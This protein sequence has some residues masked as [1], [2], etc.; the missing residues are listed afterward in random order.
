MKKQDSNTEL[1]VVDNDDDLLEVIGSELERELLK[2]VPDKD[3]TS[4][5]VNNKELLKAI[6]AYKKEC[7]DAEA[8]GKPLPRVSDYIGYCFIKMS[9]RIA[10]KP[11]FRNYPHI[12]EM[13]G[14]SI[15]NCLKYVRNFDE[16]KSN[17][18][19][20]YSTFIHNAFF[21]RIETEKKQLYVQALK[22]RRMG[23]LEDSYDVMDEDEADYH[24]THVAFLQEN[25][26]DI[27]TDFETRL[28][29]KR[30]KVN[31]RKKEKVVAK[32]LLD[33]AKK[34]PKAEK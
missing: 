4:H 28:K 29:K 23:N 27:I 7:D 26:D 15:E 30:D 33:K 8:L 32:G 22:V 18:F 17:P 5:Y 13:V 10:T 2:N 20:Y 14:D 12:E 9:E 21:R 31:L 6:V 11:C 24:N 1:L 16:T 3:N 34:K 25:G 19:A